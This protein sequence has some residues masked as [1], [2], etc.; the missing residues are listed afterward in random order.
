MLLAEGKL[1]LPV[2]SDL[3]TYQAETPSQLHPITGLKLDSTDETLEKIATTAL[4]GLQLLRN[5]RRLFI[6]YARKDAREVAK[7][8]FSSFAERGFDVFLDTHSVPA[9]STFQNQLWHSMV[10]SD[11]VVLLDTDGVE[12]SRWCRAE[13]ERADALSIGV[14]RVIWP[15]RK[16][17]PATDALQLSHPVPLKAVDFTGSPASPGNTD[18]LVHEAIVRIADAV[19]GFRARSIAAR[20]AKLITTFTREAKLASMVATVQVNSHI[21]V[22]KTHAAGIPKV[23]AVVPTVGVPVS[24][25]YHDAFVEYEGDDI[26]VDEQV[27]LFDRQGFLPQWVSHLTWLHGSLPVKG[28]DIAEVPSWLSTR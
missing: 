5:R 13:Y 23:V 24:T 26:E 11:L 3:N 6:S 14:V 21:L 27:V 17:D 10:D 20:Q 19:E 28:I 15:N 1:I 12:S 18:T 7:Q 2:V 22:Q 16:V 25:N 8:L 4:Q 9:A